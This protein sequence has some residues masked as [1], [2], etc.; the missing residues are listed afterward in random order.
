MS[1]LNDCDLVEYCLV[2]PFSALSYEYKSIV[3]N[4]RRIPE[5]KNLIVTGNKQNRSFNSDNYKKYIWS[6]GSEVRNK[7]FCWYCVLFSTDK[8]SC[9]GRS[10]YNDSKNLPR[11]F[12]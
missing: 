8:S 2:N 6:T 3:K 7:L 1:V 10:G 11:G 5:L 9:W 12:G 4:K